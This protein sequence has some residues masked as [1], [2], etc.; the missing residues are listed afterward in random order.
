MEATE[1]RAADFALLS[2]GRKQQRSV[3]G[4]A[5]ART[6]PD[7]AGDG[8]NSY[9]E[10]AAAKGDEITDPQPGNPEHGDGE[11]H[12]EAQGNGKPTAGEMLIGLVGDSPPVRGVGSASPR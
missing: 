3:G 1:Q 4:L 5:V 7:R 9:E 11:P 10:G 12:C 8:G 2:Q 6:F